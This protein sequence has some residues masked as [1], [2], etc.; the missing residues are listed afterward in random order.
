MVYDLEKL[1][2]ISLQTCEGSMHNL[3]ARV[4]SLHIGIWYVMVMHCKKAHMLHMEDSQT[5]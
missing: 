4:G 5:P 3:G 1:Q 2:H